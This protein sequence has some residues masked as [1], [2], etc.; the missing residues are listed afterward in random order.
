MV[1]LSFISPIMTLKGPTGR[2][3]MERH[4]SAMFLIRFLSHRV[5]AASVALLLVAHLALTF[6][7]AHHQ[8]HDA[9]VAAHHCPACNVVASSSP[10]PDMA[11]VV[12]P[13]YKFLERL[14]NGVLQAARPGS[15]AHFRSRAPPIVLLG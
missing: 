15:T 13:T 12:A 2:I 6:H 7:W 10:A 3:G 4:R 1:S 14:E 5:K 9:D 11:H 8:A